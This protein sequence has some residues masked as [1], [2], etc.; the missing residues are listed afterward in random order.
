MDSA[1]TMRLVWNIGSNAESLVGLWLICTIP[2]PVSVDHLFLSEPVSFC[3]CLCVS[4]CLC[5]SLSLS[6]THALVDL[7]LMA[8]LLP[9]VV[10]IQACITTAFFDLWSLLFFLF[11][12]PFVHISQ[13][14]IYLFGVRSGPMLVLADLVFTKY[15]RMSSNLKKCSD[16][17]HWSARVTAVVLT[18]PNTVTL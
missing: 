8:I 18:L 4:L 9:Q 7:K 2:S 13:F 14:C 1:R 12:L 11:I 3:V 17:S 6:I 16:L 15:A 10:L 5:L